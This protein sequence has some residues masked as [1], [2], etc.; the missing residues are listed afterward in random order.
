[1]EDFLFILYKNKQCERKA[2][3]KKGD[4]NYDQDG[5]KW[6]ICWASL[7]MIL[8]AFCAI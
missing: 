3:E 6:M 8:V 5:P 1:M 7:I 2:K 4:E